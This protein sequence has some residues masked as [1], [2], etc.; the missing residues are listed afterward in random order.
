MRAHFSNVAMRWALIGG[1]ALCTPWIVSHSKSP[2]LNDGVRAPSFRIG[3]ALNYRIDWQRYAGA[4]TA[5]LQIL[6]RSDFD[7][8]TAWHFRATIHTAEPVRVLYPMDDQIDSYAA[9]GN[10]T[11]REFQERLR[12]FGDLENTEALL[13]SPADNTISSGPRVVVPQGTHDALAAIYFLRSIDWVSVQKIRTPVFDG[14]NIYEMHAKYRGSS[15]MHITAGTYE[16]TEIE[17]QLF[18]GGKQVPD[19]NFNLWLADNADHTPLL[20]EANLSIGRVRIELIS[21]SASETLRRMLPATLPAGSSH[22]VE[23]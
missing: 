11:S 20:C 18:D 22:R 7:S 3:E 17:I 23:N 12:E 21:D 8:A 13:A 10:F 5:Q 2:A 19:E 4:A 9:A 14:Q 6:D 1:I 16:A 15:A